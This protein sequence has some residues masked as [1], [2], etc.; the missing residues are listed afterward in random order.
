[1]EPV[2]RLSRVERIRQ[3]VDSK[4]QG[5]RLVWRLAR[6]PREGDAACFERL[7]Q[8]GNWSSPDGN[9]FTV[10]DAPRA[11]AMAE[12]VE[13]VPNDGRFRHVRDR[14]FF[15]WRFDN[16][17][18]DYRF[19]YLERKGVLTGFLVVAR[20]YRWRIPFNIVDWE[21]SSDGVHAALLQRTLKSGR[22][23]AIGAW[24]A[25]LSEDCRRLL[26]Q[27]DFAATDLERRSRGMP[28]VLLKNLRSAQGNELS[29][30]RAQ[31]D[32]RL[33]DSMHG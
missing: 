11:E 17:T 27:H 33:I 19:L 15:D 5:K 1:M 18:R 31:W 29:T 10:D 32:I 23:N 16:P 3:A 2:A 25:S 8:R 4:V 7:D 9:R 21:A 13:R 14:S 12:L 22:F 26:T 24:S 20:Y 30:D 6:E 28:C